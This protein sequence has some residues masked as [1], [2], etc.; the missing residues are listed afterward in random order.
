ME[1][2]FTAFMD[3]L[4]YE[5]GLAK[6]T[7]A[8][9]KRDLSKFVNYNKNNTDISQFEKVQKDDIISFLGWQLDSGASYASVA[10]SLSTLKTFYKYL[11]LEN[12]VQDNPTID[13]ETPRIKRTLPQILTIEEIDHLFNQ[14]NLIK[15]LGIRDRAML[16]LMY[17]TGVRVSELLAVE[18]GDLNTTAG[19]LRCLG[20]GRKERIIPVNQTSIDW[21]NR[22]VTNVRSTLV[23]NHLEK[24]LFVNANGRPMSRQGFFKILTNYAQESGIKKDITPHTLRHSFATHILNNGADLRAVQEMLGHADISTTQIYTHLT[25]IRLREVYQQFHPRA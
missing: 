2:Y 16:E 5:R 23:K 15:P 1:S 17:G 11:I 22:Y 8:A 24:T 7:Q 25:T 18:M 9:Y 6:N 21:I 13:I 10:R 4:A 19:F 12:L 3:Y 20:K 14:P